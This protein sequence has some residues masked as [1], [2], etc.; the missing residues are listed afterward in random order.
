LPRLLAIA[1]MTGEGDTMP[2]F[3]FCQDEA[4][5]TF[6]PMLAWNHDLP[7]S[8]ANVAWE[9]RCLLPVSWTFCLCWPQTMILLISTAH[10]VRFIGISHQCPDCKLLF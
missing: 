4:T 5:W 10:V 8:V 9:D 6:L 7:I 1:E 3:F 2:S